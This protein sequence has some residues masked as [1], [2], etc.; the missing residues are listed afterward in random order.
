MHPTWNPW[1]HCGRTRISSPA[2]NSARQMAQSENFSERSEEYVSLGKDLRTFFFK[3]VLAGGADLRSEI[4]R[5]HAHRATATSPIMQIRA[6]RRAARITTKSASKLL[7]S[8]EGDGGE[9]DELSVPRIR[10]GSPKVIF[11]TR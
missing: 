11:D 1:P 4:R 10:E 9:D 5:I 7:M 8:E 2:M 3:G 6:H